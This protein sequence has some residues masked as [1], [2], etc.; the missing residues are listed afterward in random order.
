MAPMVRLGTS[1][2]RPRPA[3]LSGDCKR[4]ALRART[5]A[6]N[7][8]VRERGVEFPAS[9]PASAPHV[10]TPSRQAARERIRAI[11]EVKPFSEFLTD[12]FQRQHDYLRI[13]IT[14]RC[15]LRCLYCM[16]EGAQTLDE[17]SRT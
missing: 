17:E 1:A 8:A 10:P 6:T 5:I 4:W 9:V 11:E 15:N 3:V 12:N 2:V 13:S 7:A 14:E 16:P